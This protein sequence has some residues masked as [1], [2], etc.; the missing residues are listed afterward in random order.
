MSMDVHLDTLMATYVTCVYMRM[1]TVLGNMMVVSLL[2]QSELPNEELNQTAVC[3]T[4][5]ND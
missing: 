1:L 3:T 4:A 5:R 2:N